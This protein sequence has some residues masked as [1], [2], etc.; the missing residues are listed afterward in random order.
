MHVP[1]VAHLFPQAPQL[2]T[3]ADRSAHDEPQFTL[4]VAHTQAPAVHVAVL[5]HLVPQVPQLL[6]SV[7]RFAQAPGEVGVAPQS[8]LPVGHVPQVPLMH[9]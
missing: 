3:S 8:V 2:F 9:S 5:G 4:P 1:P 7:C 6:P